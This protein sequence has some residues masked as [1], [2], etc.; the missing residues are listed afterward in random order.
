M[1]FYK[2]ILMPRGSHY[3]SNY[4]IVFSRKLNRVVTLYSNLEYENYLT[5]EMDPNVVLFC[6]QPY[7]AELVIDNK[8]KKTVFDVW[9]KYKDGK[10]EFQE[11]KYSTELDETKENN[12]RTINQIRK[13]RQWCFNNDR[14]YVIRTEKDIHAGEF[15]IRNLA[16]LSS[17][18]RRYDNPEL[19]FYEME[20][21]KALRKQEKI[22]LQEI[23]QQSIFP[24][25]Y[26]LNILSL[27]YYMGLIQ[28]NIRDR[29]LDYATEVFLW[30]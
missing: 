28:M 6:E 5:L 23:I 24:I 27:F 9:V 26:E 19:S 21:K 12:L 14:A 29:P 22:E 2:P 20:L 18:V 13:Q 15:F 11:I 3:G 30:Q 10:E 1:E 25:N 16:L 8:L 7:E 17:K 4:W